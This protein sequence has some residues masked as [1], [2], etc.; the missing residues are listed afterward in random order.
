[1]Q[2]TAGEL[3]GFKQA[4]RRRLCR[5]AVVVM[6]MAISAC[7]SDR[8]ASLAGS[9]ARAVDLPGA[10]DTIDF[11]D[12]V[13]SATLGRVIVPAGRSGLYL[14]DPRTSDA[15][16][17]GHVGSADS[18]DEGAGMVFVAERDRRAITGLDAGTGR[19]TFSLDVGTPIDYV[20]YVEP[21]ELW[22]T[23][24]A[25]S[26]SGVEIFK[27]STDRESAPR[28]VGFIAVPDGPEALT[29]S[30]Q[31]A[32]AFT[33][34]GTD[35]VALDLRS[36]SVTARWP[37]GC[38]GTHGFPQIDTRR[39]L[40]LASCS[41][42]GTVSLLSLGDGRRLG[43]FA[44]GGGD[45]LPAYS[46]TAGHFYVRGDPGRKLSTLKAT[47]S[48]LTEVDHVRVPRVGHCLTADD[49]GH[50]WTCDAEHG[51]VLRFDDR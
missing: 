34:A 26:P 11:D 37:T 20:R 25:A 49:V 33:H 32:S 51:R 39:H 27:L 28:H 30:P 2:C 36:R 7:G 24:P 50:Y 19:S 40:A 14:I 13:Y 43:R 18:A 12:I 21:G 3:T 8:T 16:R 6:A 9:S 15:Q 45:A 17:L 31:L 29:V 42:D 10:E 5:V 1:M 48:G 35:L 23:E 47:K 4:P 44:A 41:R 22:V 38:S 46:R